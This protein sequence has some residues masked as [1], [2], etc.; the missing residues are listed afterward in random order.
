[1][2]R[3]GAPAA[4]ARLVKVLLPIG[5]QAR[6]VVDHVREVVHHKGRYLR[7]EAKARSNVH[8]PITRVGAGNININWI[9]KKLLSK[10]R[11]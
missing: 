5:A 10:R 3:L 6:D 4:E 7:N 2:L 8:K 11:E 1:M 9:D